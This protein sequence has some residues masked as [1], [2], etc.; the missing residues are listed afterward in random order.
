ME[1][2]PNEK[3]LLK[4]ECYAI[5]GAIY[6]VY[7]EMGAGFLEAVYQE[8][9]C[10]EFQKR[11]IPFQAKVTLSLTYKGERLMQTYE[12][13]FICYDQIIV[14]LKALRE[15]A[16]KHR[17]QVLNYLK[18]ASLHLGLLVNFGHYPKATVE[19]FVI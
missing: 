2:T 12:P 1:E 16:M 10:K 19:R 15:T 17:A 14:E 9:L 4:E 7:H 6:E 13:D 18:A 11:G 3:L 5:Q 8:C